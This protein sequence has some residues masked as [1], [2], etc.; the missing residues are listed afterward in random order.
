MTG[1]R[2]IATSAAELV[3]KTGRV[4]VLVGNASEKIWMSKMLTVLWDLYFYIH[5]KGDNNIYIYSNALSFSLESV[6]ERSE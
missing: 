1:L 3:T 4:K 5:H 6:R 2:H